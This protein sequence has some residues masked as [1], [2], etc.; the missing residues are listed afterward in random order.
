M[1][2]ADELSILIA[3]GSVA[4]VEDYIDQP[5][6]VSPIGRLEIDQHVEVINDELAG[7]NG[8]LVRLCAKSRMQILLE[9]MGSKTPASGEPMDL[10][11]A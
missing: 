6:S 5:C 11:F 2:I 8:D 4:E 1:D 9:I 3:L 7:L 10:L